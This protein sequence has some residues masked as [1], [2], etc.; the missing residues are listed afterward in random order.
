MLINDLLSNLPDESLEA[1]ARDKVSD[2]KHVR[3]PRKVLIKE[4]RDALTSHSYISKALSMK[5]PP[6]FQMILVLLNADDYS[7]P[8]QEYRPKVL[9]ETDKMIEIAQELVA[10]NRRKNY[11]LYLNILTSAWESELT[12][13]VS[14]AALLRT[15]REE[16]Y[17]TFQEHFVLMHHPDLKKLWQLEG[18][19]EKERGFLLGRGIIMSTESDYLIAEDIVP[20]IRSAWEI[21][22][23]EVQYER[24][25]SHFSNEALHELLKRNNLP[26]SGTKANKIKTIIS[27]LI[28]PRNLTLQMRITELHK[29]CKSIGCAIYGTKE[30]VIDR[31]IDYMEKDQD[32]QEAIPSKH[33]EPK[34]EEKKALTETS[35]K[36]LMKNFS[37][38]E[39]YQMCSR[40]EGLKVSGS[41]E[42]KILNLWQSQYSE[43]TMLQNFR[44][45]ELSQVCGNLRLHRSGSK[46][47][48]IDRLIEYA[49]TQQPESAFTTIQPAEIALTEKPPPTKSPPEKEIPEFFHIQK[50]YPALTRDEHIVLSFLVSMKSINESELDRIISL[51][52]LNWF[53]PK[54][55]MRDLIENLKKKDS[56]MRIIVKPYKYYNI[57]EVA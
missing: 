54:A 10:N 27:S 2:I 16:L 24:L 30:E 50:Q 35:F 44:C 7:C 36:I 46:N 33:E 56:D 43:N 26:T 6:C 28:S 31:I 38:D 47:D 40:L 45:Q 37:F 19:Y 21:E 3:L 25:L 14:E 57:Y 32:I 51:Y 20:V 22:L 52:K 34:I 29:V 17:I 53:L 1:L 23:S 42:V 11:Q 48:L 5:Y 39:L 15:L 49:K 18:A 41:K 55:H 12:I 8:V 9:S 4:I 13:D